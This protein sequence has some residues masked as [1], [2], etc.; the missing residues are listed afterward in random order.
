M[1]VCPKTVVPS[2]AALD[3]RTYR[4][5][6]GGVSVSLEVCFFSLIFIEELLRVVVSSADDSSSSD[7]KS[8]ALS[9]NA[10]GSLGSADEA[11]A[12]T[13]SED[14]SALAADAFDLRP[15]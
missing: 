5:L 15:G 2:L 3:F 9:I 4:R 6:A 12:L 1:A 14:S 10:E 11:A 7:L 8:N 13:G